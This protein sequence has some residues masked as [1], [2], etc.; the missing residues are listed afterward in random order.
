ME[1]S[2]PLG[3]DLT[4]LAEFHRRGVRLAGPVHSSNNQFADS[5]TDT[6]RWNGLSPLGRQW[7]AEMNRLGM[8]IDASHA[9]DD[10]FDQMLALS[11]TPDRKS[12]RLNSST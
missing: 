6:P 7:V 1:N 11:K 12:T 10:A 3:E 9:S 4:L 2:Y 5:A 8:E